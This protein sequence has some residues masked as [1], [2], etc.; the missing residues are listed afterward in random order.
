MPANIYKNKAG[1]RIPGV[2]TVIGSNLGW[3][4]GGLMHW[5][6]EEGINGRDYRETRDT[7]ASIGTIAHKMVEYEIKGKKF[8]WPSMGQQMG[9]NEEQIEQAQNAFNEFVNW[10]ELVKFKLMKSEHLLISDQFNYGGQ[11]DIA[12][13]QGK[14]ALID[15]KTSNE[16]YPDHKIQLSAYDYLW[17]ENYP[18]DPVNA[19]YILRLGKSGGFAY[20]SLPRIEIV[21][22]FRAFKLLRELHD[23]KKKL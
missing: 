12:A 21:T 16:I 1:E 14:T 19:W 9:A 22:G 7:A 5:A 15:I 20:Y 2:T 18:G 4:K 3:S 6:W 8:D 13:V 23:L 17:N 11:I 10:R